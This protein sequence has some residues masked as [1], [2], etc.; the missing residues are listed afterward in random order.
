MIQFFTAASNRVVFSNPDVW[1]KPVLSLVP[2]A[3]CYRVVS[4]TCRPTSEDI[5]LIPD[6]FQ[7]QSKS[8]FDPSRGIFAVRSV[9]A[10]D[11]LN[12][13]LWIWQPKGNSFWISWGTGFGGIRGTFKR[14]SNGEFMGKVSE[15]CDYRCDWKRRTGTIRIQQIACTL[16]GP[17]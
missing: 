16:I 15:W 12:E 11:N 7:L 10:S 3:G 6:R 4:Q 8:A 9:P 14:S 5:K 13:N 17:V 2:F 1:P